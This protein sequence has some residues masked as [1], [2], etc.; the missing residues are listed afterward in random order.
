M[1]R[2]TARDLKQ[3]NVIEKIL[4]EFGGADAATAQAI[5]EYMKE[6][7]KEFLEHY[8]GMSG[9]EIAQQRYERFRSY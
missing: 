7:I 5:G 6:Q 2:I 1:M 8:R 3:L 4:P 9:Q